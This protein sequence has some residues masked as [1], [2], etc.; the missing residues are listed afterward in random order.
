MIFQ[1]PHA[2]RK[3]PN[4]LGHEWEI[5]QMNFVHAPLNFLDLGN[6]WNQ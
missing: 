2:L 3:T 5:F 4:H 1:E 6:L